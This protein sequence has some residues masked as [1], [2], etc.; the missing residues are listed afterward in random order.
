MIS[1]YPRNEIR[2]D[3]SQDFAGLLAP[4][5]SIATEIGLS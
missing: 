1:D 2:V 5:D 3:W 4:L